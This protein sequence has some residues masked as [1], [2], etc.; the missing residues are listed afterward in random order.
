MT[1]QRYAISGEIAVLD[2]TSVEIT[3]LPVG[4]WTQTYKEKVLEV[5]INGT[6]KVPAKIQ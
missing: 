1:E 3:E 6:D 2:E 4:V 5:M